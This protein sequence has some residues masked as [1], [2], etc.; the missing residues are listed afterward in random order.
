MGVI[1]I[2]HQ[3]SDSDNCRSDVYVSSLA[4]VKTADGGGWMD[5]GGR[6]D[7]WIV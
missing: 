7:G 3:S 4:S 5:G 6:L 2:N 1:V